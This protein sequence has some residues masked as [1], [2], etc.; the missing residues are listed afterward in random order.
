[1]NGKQ[2]ELVPRGGATLALALSLLSFVS[3]SCTLFDTSEPEESPWPKYFQV[4]FSE[5]GV[6]VSTGVDRGLPERI[7]EMIRSA[8]KSVDINIYELA[9]AAIYEPVIEMHRKGLKV[10]MVGSINNTHYEGYKALMAAGVPM[11]LGNPDKIMHNKF[12]VVDEYKVSMGSMNYTGSG[13]LMNN[14]NVVFI[15]DK[16]VGAYYTKEMDNMFINGTFGLEKVPFEGF[17]DNV[18]ELESGSPDEEKTIIKVYFTPYVGAFA[19]N[20]SA[21]DAI[22]E[23]ITNAKHTIHFAVF[24]FTSVPIADAVIERATNGV[25]VFGVFDKGWHEASVW[26]A[27]QRLLDAGVNVRMDGNEHYYPN[28]PYHGSKIHDKIMTIDAGYE[29]SVTLT[30]SFNFSPSAAVQGNDENCIL[31]YN[32]AIA[33]RYRTELEKLYRRGSHPTKA[34]GGEEAGYLEVIID[35]VNWA[36]SRANESATPG[37]SRNNANDKYVVLK[38][39]THRDINISGWQLWGTTSSTYRILGH[40]LPKGT[41]L[42]ADGY[43][44]IGYSDIESGF[45]WTWAGTPDNPCTWSSFEY[46][47]DMHNKARQN[48]IYLRLKD[49]DRNYIDVAGQAGVAPFYGQAGSTFE[50]MKRIN[51]DGTLRSSW[52]TVTTAGIAVKGAYALSTHATPG[53]GS[54][55]PAR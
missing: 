17:T 46:L 12:V 36:G 19:P 24:A 1:M 2:N 49:V 5:P 35:E 44:V 38:N 27:H 15:Q 7:G 22:L 34:L 13:A 50:A 48:Y 9:V 39:R 52:E 28:N 21:N 3:L 20:S 31:I 23:A 53:E 11:R 51:L 8:K 26:S 29:G 25:Q 30:G 4:F 43:H 41:I 18:F 6:S 45:D 10:R 32:K 14:E 37:A 16:G 40:I 55:F 54:N 47:G 33:V 42:K